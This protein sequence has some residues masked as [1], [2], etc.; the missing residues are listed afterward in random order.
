VANCNVANE[1]GLDCASAITLT[2]SQLSALPNAGVSTTY[3]SG[4]GADRY[5][6]DNGEIHE[7]LDAPSVTAANIT[8]PTLSKAKV[9]AF[10]YL[11]FGAPI[12]SNGSLFI[13][14]S[15]NQEGIY[16][17]GEF[18]RI[19][20]AVAK[21]ID[22]A[23]WFTPSAGSLSPQGL[24][25][26]ETGVT[27]EPFVT[28]SNG[29]NWLISSTGKRKV[30]ASSPLAIATGQVDAQLL[31]KIPTSDTEIGAPA[32]VSTAAQKATYYLSAGIARP[33]YSSADRTALASQAKQSGVI[34]L[35]PSAFAQL[36][37]GPTLVAP[38]SVVKA[39]TSGDIYLVNNFKA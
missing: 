3:V 22:F 11:P 37:L 29:N 12:A 38:G 20:A 8:L 25:A 4:D 16:L 28:D 10:K 2:P 26:V 31:S 23:K 17:T 19:D 34:F 32:F 14:R 35:Q 5:L 39:K 6:I 36:N 30:T 18:Y 13:D 7:I 21:E 15:T 27:L 33:I 9:S 24:S 1:L